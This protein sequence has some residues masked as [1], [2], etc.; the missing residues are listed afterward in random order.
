M[1]DF[2]T[3]VVPCDFSEHARAALA[4]A[5]DLA[6][7]LDAEIHLLHVVQPPTL[8]Y[9]ASG[10]YAPAVPAPIDM[11]EL[12]ASAATA[13]DEL[14]A[15]LGDPGKFEKHVVESPSI[16]EAICE[17]AQQLGADLVVMGTH[18]RTGLAHIFLGSVAERTLRRAPCPVLTVRAPDASEQRKDKLGM[19]T[20]REA[21]ERLERSGFREAFRASPD[22]FLALQTRRIYPPDT[23]IV[24]E[25]VRF[26]GES[27]PQD[28]AVLYALRA[29]DD[30]VR[31][32]FVASFGPSADPI[33]GD[34]IKR[35]STDSG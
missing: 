8:A 34:L 11:Q 22:G 24:E 30:S 31:G 16:E 14:A 28:E 23:L 32:T 19:E 27:D 2:R 35:L 15:G 9:V 17:C 20:L 21:I 18:G 10:V 7:R 4:V 29:R 13:L 5:C 25:V 33:S 6:R 3:F 12:R 1:S 26:E